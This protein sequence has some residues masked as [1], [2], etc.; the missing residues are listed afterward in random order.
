MRS[1]TATELKAIAL[2]AMRDGD[3]TTLALV[4][5]ETKRRALAHAAN[6]HVK[7]GQLAA[8]L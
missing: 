5:T 3:Q 6:G 8:K 1:K 7:L 4:R 2:K